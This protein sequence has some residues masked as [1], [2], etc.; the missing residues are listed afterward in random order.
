MK[1][2]I[3]GTSYEGKFCPNC[4]A[5]ATTETPVVNTVPSAPVAEAKKKKPIYKKWWFWVIIAI[6]VI[7]IIGGSNGDEET[8]TDTSAGS[9]IAQSNDDANSSTT[10]NNST[11]DN[12]IVTSTEASSDNSSTV[13]TTYAS[14][15]VVNRFI[16][17]FNKYSDFEMSDIRKGN[18][19]TKFFAYANDCYVEMINANDAA[20]E[21]FSIS[22]NG[23]KET[24]D[25]TKMLEVAADVIKVLDFSISDDKIAQTIT[26][27]EG[28]QYM[29]N[30]YKI[31]E[32][33]LVE[34]YVPIVELSY[35]KSDCRIDIISYDFKN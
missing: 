5:P 24:T 26:Y 22:I 2:N 27:L 8:P 30:D 15:D 33:V 32:D 21:C 34:T 1:C 31:T 29:V 11:K 9:F 4:G 18:I 28:E 20:A 19:R 12:D 17:E 7:G 25:R 3:C 14:D 23:G 35:G 13:E 16:N 10:D 6:V